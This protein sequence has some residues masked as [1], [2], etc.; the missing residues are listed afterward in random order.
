M[1]KHKREWKLGHDHSLDAV[2]RP[3]TIVFTNM[4]SWVGE[5]LD[6]EL[7]GCGFK[8]HAGHVLKFIQFHFNTALPV[9]SG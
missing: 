7:K 9:S 2:T 3:T 4:G 5:V 1:N 6:S 8:A